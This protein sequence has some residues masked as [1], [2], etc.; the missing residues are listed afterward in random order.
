MI[1]FGGYNY[2]QF[3]TCR[4][5]CINKTIVICQMSHQRRRFLNELNKLAY[6]WIC[7]LYHLGSLALQP[8]YQFLDQ[9]ADLFCWKSSLCCVFDLN[10]R[11][12]KFGPD[13]AQTKLKKTWK[14]HNLLNFCAWSLER[15]D[16][17][18]WLAVLFISKLPWYKL[19]YKIFVLCWK[20]ILKVD[21]KI[22]CGDIQPRNPLST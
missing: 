22:I 6:I 10:C 8:K 9:L 12:F 1:H 5:E 13:M 14:W 18:F 7:T 11:Q 17:V 15:F 20:Y 16:P 2:A 3:V 19:R 4:R 21:F